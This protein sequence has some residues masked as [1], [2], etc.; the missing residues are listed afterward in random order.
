MLTVS[1][2]FIFILHLVSSFLSFFF[3]FKKKTESFHQQILMRIIPFTEVK[4]S[5]SSRSSPEQEDGKVMTPWPPFFF[6]VL[7]PKVKVEVKIWW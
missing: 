7:L 6:S 1:G 3:L 4:N 5:V 2:Q